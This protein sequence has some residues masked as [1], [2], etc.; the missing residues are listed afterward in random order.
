MGQPKGQPAC[1]QTDFMTQHNHPPQAFDA[2]SALL[3]WYD[4]GHRDLPWRHTRDPYAIWVSEIMLQ[5][6]Q[7]A[8]VLDRFPR[9]MARFPIVNALAAA[10]EDAVLHEWAGLGYYRRA[11]L[12]HRA[13]GEIVR[14]WGG[15]FPDS[16]AALS[17]L[18]GVGRSTAGA[19]AAI[20]FALPAP[21]LDGNVRRVLT[22]QLDLDLPADRGRGL[23][24]L[25]REAQART[26]VERPGDYTQAIM[27]LGATLCLP[28]QPRCIDCPWCSSCLALLR[29]TILQRP[30]RGS[31]QKVQEEVWHL[32]LAERDEGV[33]LTK[34]PAHGIWGSLWSLPVQNDPPLPPFEILGT[35]SHRLT[36]RLLTL[37]PYRVEDA[38]GTLIPWGEVLSLGLPQPVGR[39]LRRHFPHRFSPSHPAESS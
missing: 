20:A 28:R 23:D 18:P 27:E 34:R 3:A 31:A 29:Q 7:V 8:T 32:L 14:T 12:L 13:A 22:R 1:H 4:R 21:I 15:S 33:I 39:L 30:V 36:H 2:A 11:R 38:P 19:I 16:V 25:W 37:I 5:Q 9:F 24:L 10:D 35:I 17:S 26:S 6:T